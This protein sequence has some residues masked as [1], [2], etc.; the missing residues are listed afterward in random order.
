MSEGNTGDP[1]GSSAWQAAMLEWARSD[2]IARQKVVHRLV[3][4][5]YLRWEDTTD[6][7]AFFRA[8]TSA[9]EAAPQKE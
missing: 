6:P 9:I 1:P 7:D 2:R 3:D 5:G 8:L 4:K